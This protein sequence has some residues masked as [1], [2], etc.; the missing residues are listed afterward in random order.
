[1]GEPSIQKIYNSRVHS[2]NHSKLLV[3]LFIFNLN[4]PYLQYWHNVGTVLHKYV[5]RE[6]IMNMRVYSLGI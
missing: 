2:S 3:L 4:A 6:R 1:M 5:Q